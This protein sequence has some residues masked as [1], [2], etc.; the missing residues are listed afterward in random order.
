M[1]LG[2]ESRIF[3]A[4]RYRYLQANPHWLPILVT[5]VDSL[6]NLLALLIYLKYIQFLILV[7]SIGSL[8]K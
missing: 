6:V 4:Q 2:W 3:G 5:S 8:V 1:F 7:T